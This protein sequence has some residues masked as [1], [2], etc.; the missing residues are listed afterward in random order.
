MVNTH[1]HNPIQRVASWHKG[2]LD[3]AEAA[4]D[5]EARDLYDQE[6]KKFN[7]TFDSVAKLD[8][9]KVDKIDNPGEVQTGG[10]LS[11][12]SGSRSL[13]KTDDGFALRVTSGM[14]MFGA[15][16]IGFSAFSN[17]FGAA[18]M[19][20]TFE[21]TEYQMNEKTGTI[22]VTRH[23]TKANNLASDKVSESFILDTNNGL[24]RDLEQSNEFKLHASPSEG[25]RLGTYYA[26]KRGVI[27]GGLLGRDPSK[28]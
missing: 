1:I 13:K 27:P 22:A 10:I 19:A 14:G 5:Q 21:S 6:I 28:S 4:K 26:T 24:M 23:T 12:L 7:D 20:T 3:K 15:A 17:V 9:G 2:Q 16:T 18:P 11:G 25:S 8:G